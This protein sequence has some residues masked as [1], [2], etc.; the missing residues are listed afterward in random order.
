MGDKSYKRYKHKSQFKE[1]GK[2]LSHNA[3]E[4]ALYPVVQKK[5]GEDA[6]ITTVEVEHLAKRVFTCKIGIANSNKSETNTWTVVAKTFPDDSNLVKAY[7]LMEDF[8]KEGF[9]R[10][11][12]DN[13]SIPEPLCLA[14]DIKF[15]FMEMVSGIK[16]RK[17]I[18]DA[19]NNIAYMRWYAQT[20][21][22]MQRC[23]IQTN[24][25]I[26]LKNEF[27]KRKDHYQ[28]LVAAYPELKNSVNY[29][30]ENSVR[31][32]QTFATDTYMLVHGDY[33]LGQLHISEDHCWLLD[34]GEICMGDPAWD[35][36]NVLSLSLF[37]G[38]KPGVDNKEVLLKIFQDEYFSIMDHSIARRVPLY[39]AYYLLDRTCKYQ[40]SQEP[41][42]MSKIAGMITQ[43]VNYVESF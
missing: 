41:D 7:E 33:N 27:D 34:F 3:V 21:A 42:R 29:I 38:E 26:T 19:E 28:Q 23:P 22:K 2:A 12:K 5:F 35:V 17:L 9:F 36:G 30:I 4:Q 40:R 15:M 31:I 39:Q 43:A 6:K 25:T 10:A 37:T 20:L 11:A 18:K 13:I 24:E 32:E 8:W 14:I 16:L 1:L